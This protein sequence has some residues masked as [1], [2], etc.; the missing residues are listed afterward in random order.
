MFSIQ[1]L[2]TSNISVE[3]L[4]K[5]LIGSAIADTNMKLDWRVNGKHVCEHCLIIAVLWIAI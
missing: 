3:V 2:P 1:S 4:A 5:S